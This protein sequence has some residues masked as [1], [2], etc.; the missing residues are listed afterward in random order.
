MSTVAL[1]STVLEAL[2]ALGAHYGPAMDQAAAELGLSE[3]YG[4]LL[5]ALVFE[6]EPISATRLRVR[7]PYTSARL[8]NERLAKAARQGFL[9]QVAE[10]ENEYHLTELGRQAAERVIEAAYVKM[11]AF[12]PISSPELER[13]ASLLHRL[14]LSCLTAPEPPGKWCIIH[15]RRTDPG[16]NA[17]A[18]VR[19]DQYLSDLAAYRDDAHLATWQLHNIDGHAWE[20]FTY[21]WRAEATT[22]DGLYQKLERR[23][24]SRDEYRR[25]LEDL[26]Q[27]GWVREEAGEYQVTIL[28]QE[29]RQAAEEATDQYFYAPWSCLSQGET[30]ELRTLLMLFRDG[31]RANS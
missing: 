17:S 15:S 4:W 8:Y 23:G 27:R 31:L 25:A 22:L 13:L 7:S 20:A 26:L 2:Q 9:T 30:E 18:M 12:Q 10:A 24:Y 21:L 29:I 1:W 14:V 19:I 3:W 5:P 16:D 6:P 28:G 11:A